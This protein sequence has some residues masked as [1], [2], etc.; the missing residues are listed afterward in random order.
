MKKKTISLILSIILCA[1]NI[2]IISILRIS[3]TIKI[4]TIALSVICLIINTIEFIIKSRTSVLCSSFLWTMLIIELVALILDISNI[5]P[6]LNSIEATSDWIKSFGVTSWIIFLIIQ[7]LQVVVLPIP[8]Q[9]TTI[10]GVIIFGPLQTFVISSVAVILGSLACFGIGRLMGDKILNKLAEPD[11]VEKY[12]NMITKR[13]KVLLPIFFILPAFPDDLLCFVAGATN[14]TWKYFT[15]ITIT[16]RLFGILCICWFGTGSIIPFNSWGIP[17]WIAIIS[18]LSVAT[19]YILKNQDK[20]ENW[21]SNK[22]SV[23]SK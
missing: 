22:I 15:L 19:I 3:N 11:K 8:A 2:Y 16:T 14:M 9:I 17:V 18:I 20:I 5:L 13:G 23:K 12:K 6:K 1:L 7:I 4:I 21:I 10:S